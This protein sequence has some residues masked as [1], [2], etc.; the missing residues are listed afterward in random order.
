MNLTLRG[1]G[2]IGIVVARTLIVLIVRVIWIQ[3][4]GINGERRMQVDEFAEKMFGIRLTSFQT[5]LLK[6]DLTNKRFVWC[7]NRSRI[8]LKL[9]DKEE[10]E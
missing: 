7:F 4:V 1:K 5:D 9:V 8:W 2:L 10:K 6:K 3:D